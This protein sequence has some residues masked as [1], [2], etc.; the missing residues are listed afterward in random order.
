MSRKAATTSRIMDQFQ[1]LIAGSVLTNER[2]ARSLGVNVVDWQAFGV[3]ARAGRPLT[4]GEISSL[5]KLPTS[6]TTRVLDRL[7]QQGFIERR[8]DQTDRRRIVIQP[9]PEVMERFTSD[10]KNNPYTEIQEA[11]QQI[12]N[13]FTLDELLIVERY[14]QAV[15]SGFQSP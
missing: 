11:M 9:Q 6:T 8:P 12:H 5:T 7:E 10:S 4:P 3:I 13:G 2:I 15:N 1:E 14:L